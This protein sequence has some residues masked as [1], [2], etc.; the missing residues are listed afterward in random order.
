MKK[1]D[2]IKLL[3]NIKGNPDIVIYNG[4]VDDYMELGKDVEEFELVKETLDTKYNGFLCDAYHSKQDIESEDV[5]QKCMER[6]K[7]SYKKQKYDLPNPYTSE[8]NF[9]QRY[10]KKVKKMICLCT[11]L[12]GKTYWDRLGKIEY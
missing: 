3:Q 7:E 8:E 4:L 9:Y 5:K 6:A 10:E 12:R 2:L 1:N 11:K